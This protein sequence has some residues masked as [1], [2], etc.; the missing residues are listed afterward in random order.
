MSALS[1]PPRIG[2]AA[3]THLGLNSAVAAAAKGFETVC[4]DADR[5]LIDRLDKG[6][7]A[8]VEPDL[9]ELLANNRS[10]LAFTAEVARPYGMRR[11]L[12][13][14]R[15]AD[16]RCRHER[17]DGARPIAGAG[18][19]GARA[20]S[21]A[22]RAEPG[23]A[24]VHAGAPAAGTRPLLPGR[25]PDLRPG[26]GARAAPGAIHRRLRR[27]GRAAAPGIAGLFAGVRLSHPADA[28]G[29]RGADQDRHQLLPRL[30]DQRRQHAGRAV[31]GHR[32]RVGRDCT[33]PQ[34][35]STHRP[36]RLPQLRASA[37]PAATSS[38]T[39]RPSSAS[40][41]RSAATPAWCGPG[42]P[43]AG[44]GATG[45]RAPSSACCW[46]RPP[47]RLWPCGAWPTRRTPTR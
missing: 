24:G 2:Y 38:G 27:S 11:G 3:M 20:E 33:C 13:S 41:R 26:D 46:T 1:A 32:R 37:S 43:T 39:W 9:P 12:S 5:A 16:G 28:L 21:D 18:D 25:D 44:I 23:A 19:P 22:G 8:M 4:F 42:S 17:P 15:R 30:L 7:L 47:R 45:R 31:R 29:E 14:A 40:R 6:D 35:G 10:R 34:A 36:A